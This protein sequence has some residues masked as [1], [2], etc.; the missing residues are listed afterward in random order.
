MANE[1]KNLNTIAIADIKNVNGQTDDNIKEL[2][3]QEFQGY[4]G[5]AG[6]FHGARFLWAGGYQAIAAPSSN[7]NL[8]VIQYKSATSTG[9]TSDFGN[10]QSA[11]RTPS[12]V[13]NG[14]RFI[15][16]GGET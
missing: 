3:A 7:A 1:V 5:T 4:S 15:I 2:N 9:N 11:A 12:G 8:D 6:N 13:S 14:T 16:F 10:M